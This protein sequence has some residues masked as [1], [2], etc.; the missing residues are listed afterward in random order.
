[1]LWKRS[2]I[3]SRV[4]FL[5]AALASGE[6]EQVRALEYFQKR[7]FLGLFEELA[8]LVQSGVLDKT[9]AL[10]MFGYFAILCWKDDMFW[11]SSD[12]MGE[13]NVSSTQA[14]SHFE[15]WLETGLPIWPTPTDR[16]M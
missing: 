13:Y 5:C 2:V 10:Y 14:R 8:I 15:D 3:R 7:Y 11:G 1:M 16:S 9:V 12:A 4:W 6:P